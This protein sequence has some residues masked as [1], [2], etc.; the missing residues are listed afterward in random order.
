[1]RGMS[2]LATRPCGGEPESRPSLAI[3]TVPC[4]SDRLSQMIQAPDATVH[5]RCT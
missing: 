2:D 5:S 1:M 3:Q 4:S